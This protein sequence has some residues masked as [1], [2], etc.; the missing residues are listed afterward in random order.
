VKIE[1]VPWRGAPEPSQ[2]R[3]RHVKGEVGR[4]TWENALQHLAA[5]LEEQ[6]QIAHSVATVQLQ[7]HK[8]ATVLALQPAWERANIKNHR[9]IKELLLGLRRERSE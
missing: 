2:K 1:G 4:Q 6:K 3:K 7:N 5:T 8:R 9:C